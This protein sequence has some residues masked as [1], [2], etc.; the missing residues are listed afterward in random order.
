MSDESLPPRALPPADITNPDQL[1][2]IENGL[3]VVPSGCILPQICAKT[4]LPVTEQDMICRQLTWCSPWI[5]LLFFVSGPL[6]ILVYFVAR[7]RCSITFGLSPEIRRRN[8]QRTLVKFLAMFG[9]LIATVSLA[10]VNSAQWIVAALCLTTFVLFLISVIALFVGNSPLSV[11]R[12][13]NGMFWI[14]GFQHEYMAQLPL[15]A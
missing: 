4:N 7:K 9:L 6:L 12:H 5:G 15:E 2:R 1:I 10:T 11:V 14:K 13:R 3:L 8:S